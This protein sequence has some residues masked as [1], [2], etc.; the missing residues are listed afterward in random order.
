MKKGLCKVCGKGLTEGDDFENFIC[1]EC[2]TEVS[3]KLTLTD[4]SALREG[5]FTHNLEDKVN[6]FYLKDELRNTLNKHGK[7]IVNIAN[8]LDNKINNYQMN[9]SSDTSIEDIYNILD[10]LNKE[11]D[12][13]QSDIETGMKIH[14]VD[15]KDN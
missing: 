14:K 9:A 10:D 5:V 3:L 7:D 13:L 4:I 15:K 11:I 8:F 2:D 6:R 1:K 12:S